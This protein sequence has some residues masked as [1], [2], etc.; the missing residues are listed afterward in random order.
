VTRGPVV[1]DFWNN[2]QGQIVVPVFQHAAGTS[3]GAIQVFDTQEP[4]NA[5]WPHL[6]YPEP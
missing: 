6:P 4:F 2:G 3:G 5:L 1:E